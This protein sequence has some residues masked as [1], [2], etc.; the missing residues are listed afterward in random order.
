VTVSPTSTTTYILSAINAQGTVTASATL[1]VGSVK[2]L[3]F[4]AT[5]EFS[6]SAGNPVVITWTTS[7]ATSVVITGFGFPNGTLPVN[8]SVTVNPNTNVDYTLIAYGPDGRS[9]SAVI[10]VFV[11]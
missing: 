5:P 9:V 7:G 6:T 2:I 3:S 1:T 8:G 11:R 10:H 4:S